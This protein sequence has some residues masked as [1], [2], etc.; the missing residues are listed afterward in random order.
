MPAKGGMAVKAAKFTE[1][2]ANNAGGMTAK[3]AKRAAG[4]K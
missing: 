2:I 1:R 3:V 4:K